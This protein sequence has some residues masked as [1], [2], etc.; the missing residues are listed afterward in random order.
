AG[1][2]A[3]VAPLGTAITEDQ[4]RLMWRIHPEPVIALD[5]DAAGI[6]AALRVVDLALPLLEA[7]QGLR[8]AVL[9]PGLDPD[10]LIRAEGASAM[11]RVLEA[12]QPMV[13]LLWRRET[14]GHVFDSPER[15]AALD[16]RLRAAGQRIA[17]PSIRRHYGDELNRLRMEIFGT[18]VPRRAFHRGGKREPL[19]VAPHPSTRASLL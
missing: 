12:A 2:R 14:E 9:P 15:R 8:F 6:R 7:G 4:L 19:A 13:G 1:F 16:K 3:T 17:D 10:D 5:G 11:G 18:S